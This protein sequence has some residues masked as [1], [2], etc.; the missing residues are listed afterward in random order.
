DRQP[1]EIC[2][3]S[4]QLSGES[5][6]V[7]LQRAHLG[8]RTTSLEEGSSGGDE[9]LLLD[10]EGEV[11]SR[12]RDCASAGPRKTEAVH[13][14]DVLLHLGGAGGDRTRDVSY[15]LAPD[16]TAERRPR[17]VVRQEAA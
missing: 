5:A 16:H 4:P 10:I 1:A 2:D 9:H 13:R 3:L 12:I 17:I 7:A 15:P 6:F 11:H 14:N 8:R